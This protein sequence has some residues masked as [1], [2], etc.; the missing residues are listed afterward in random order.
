MIDRKAWRNSWIKRI[1]ERESK[2]T[3]ERV[4][5]RESKRVGEREKE[6]ERERNRKRERMSGREK[7]RLQMKKIIQAFWI[8]RLFSN[9]CF[10]SIFQK[11]D[12]FSLG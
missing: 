10:C 7:E 5:E 9:C 11:Q 12:M 4:R 1:G 8:E 2:R 3:R 6:R